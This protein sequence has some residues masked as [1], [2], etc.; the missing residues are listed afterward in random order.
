MVQT[1]RLMPVVGYYKKVAGLSPHRGQPGFCAAKRVAK[2]RED[3]CEI[4]QHQGIAR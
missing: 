3:N 2:S 4:Q 1:L